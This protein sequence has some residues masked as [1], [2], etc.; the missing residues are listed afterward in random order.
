MTLE[1]Y[2]ITSNMHKFE[3][4]SNFINNRIIIKRAV[5][6]LIEIQDEDIEKVA[7]NKLLLSNLPYDYAFVE[8]SGLFIKDLNGFPGVFS[9]YTF[10]T[11][12]LEGIIKLM[13][14]INNR[15]ATFVSVIAFKQKEKIL[16]FRGEVEGTIA[17]DIRGSNNFG[18]DPIFIPENNK[19]TFGEMDIHEKSHY[20]HRTRAYKKFL[21]Y[22]NHILDTGYP[23]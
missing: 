17:F 18:F 7:M 8:D 3:E 13:E 6:P 2:F 5:Y 12:G 15:H 9:A 14:G 22:V 16:V 23:Q 19:N 1:V 11:I 10:K 4:I 21:E 20:S